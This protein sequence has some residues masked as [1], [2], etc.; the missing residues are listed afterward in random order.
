MLAPYL[1]SLF[2]LSL[3]VPKHVA[4]C[5]NVIWPRLMVFINHGLE[6]SARF[7]VKFDNEA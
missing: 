7:V 4:C 6:L 2:K 1:K 5:D 3:C